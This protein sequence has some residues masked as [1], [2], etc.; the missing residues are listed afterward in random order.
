MH[1]KQL[2]IL[3]DSAGIGT[4]KVYAGGRSH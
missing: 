1:I 4:S 2:K 3:F